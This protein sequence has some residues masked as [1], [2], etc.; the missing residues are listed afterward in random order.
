MGHEDDGATARR[1]AGHIHA[2]VG[3][4]VDA[5]IAVAPRDAINCPVVSGVPTSQSGMSLGFVVSLFVT[6]T[7]VKPA[8][9]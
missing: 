8:R 3:Q 4:R 5:A 2:L 9:P 7:S 1:V 6:A